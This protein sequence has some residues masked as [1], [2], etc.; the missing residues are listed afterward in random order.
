MWCAGRFALGVDLSSE[1]FYVV[2]GDVD[3]SGGPVWGFDVEGVSTGS[4]RAVELEAVADGFE[5]AIAWFVGPG[6]IPRQRHD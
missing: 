1:R 4:W 3:T 2:D 6:D 5:P